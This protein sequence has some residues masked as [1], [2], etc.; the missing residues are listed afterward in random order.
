VQGDA[1]GDEHFVVVGMAMI[2]PA[3]RDMC[4]L[5]TQTRPVIE[6]IGGIDAEPKLERAAQVISGTNAQ[7]RAPKRF[8]VRLLREIRRPLPCST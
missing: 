6:L 4:D 7:A 8:I 5:Q 2:N 1:V 3:I